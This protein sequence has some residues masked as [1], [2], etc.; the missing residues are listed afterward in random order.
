MYNGPRLMMNDA[1]VCVNRSIGPRR[2]RDPQ[3]GP[4]SLCRCVVYVG[5]DRR[6]VREWRVGSVH[7]CNTHSPSC[8]T[9][10]SN[11]HT[12]AAS[13]GPQRPVR[14]RACRRRCAHVRVCVWGGSFFL[15]SFLVSWNVDLGFCLV[16]Y[17]YIKTPPPTA[18]IANSPR[19]PRPVRAPLL[20]CELRLEQP[21]AL[22]LCG[23][24]CI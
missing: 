20:P 13:H 4:A 23:C 6:R 8:L 5:I 19:M 21:H 18:A 17:T 22:V 16:H 9:T 2:S 11:E 1:R 14:P 12:W 15:P 10:A 3:R 7:R 24:T